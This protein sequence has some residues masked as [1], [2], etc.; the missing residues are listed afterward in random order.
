MTESVLEKQIIDGLR[1]HGWYVWRTHDPKHRP[2]YAGVT[3]LEAVKDGRVLF[4][5]TKAGKNQPTVEQQTHMGLLA[6]AGHD[7]IVARSWEDVERHL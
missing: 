1:R 3:D 6:A 7:A 2:A 4:I 5:E